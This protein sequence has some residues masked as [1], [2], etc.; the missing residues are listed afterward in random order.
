MSSFNNMELAKFPLVTALCT[1]ILLISLSQALAFLANLRR[2][3][4]SDARLNR[5]HGCQLPR[6]LEKKWPLGI[7]RLKQIWDANS[8]GRLLKFFCDIARDFEPLNNSYQFFL[9]GP[10]TFHILD[11]RNVS[12]ILSSN[13]TDYSFGSRASV[14]APLIG[15]GIFTQEGPAWKH[16]RDLLR[17][18]FVKAQ[19]RN[20]DHFQEHL[21]NLISCI[22]STGIIDLQPL[23]FSLTLDTA[24]ALLFGRSVHSLRGPMSQ[25][26]TSQSFAQDFT[27][28]QAGL[29]KRFRLTPFHSLYNPP[30]FRNACHNVHAFVDRYISE[31]ENGL[32]RD[33]TEGPTWFMDQILRESSSKTA[34]RS[35]LLNILL[36]GRDTTACCLS[37]TF[38]LLVRHEKVMS[39]LR[40]EIELVMPDS[41]HPTREQ[42]A[43]MPY[44]A[45]VVKES[46]RLYPPV[47][48]NIREAVTSTI[49]PVGGGVDGKNPILVRKGEVVVFSQYITSRRR[50]IFGDD[51]EEF[52]PER[53]LADK[54]SEIED[55]F[56]AFN[57]GPRRC[58]GEDFALAEVYYTII[59]LLKAFPLI[60]LPADEPN[61]VLGTERQ[62]LT[63]VL[64]SENG[65]R[66]SLGSVKN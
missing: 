63:L 35:Q 7:D 41:E 9:V 3:R 54:T 61:E 53:W 31:R 57:S 51:A 25:D 50:N 19:Y 16:S 52:R 62:R 30:S 40:K 37:W 4:K 66:V 20:L 5:E 6:E 45:S 32:G 2:T 14:F 43:R 64:A 28:A 34:A 18:Q 46:L 56:F 38:R 23:F 22:P 10:R 17:K 27:T 26:V 65:C 44:L 47:P 58:L 48:L 33:D 39:H 24:T 11:P 59:R 13:F 21:D 15:E 12:T 36:A 8:D 49:L 55:A 1:G 60:Q 29:A 42:I